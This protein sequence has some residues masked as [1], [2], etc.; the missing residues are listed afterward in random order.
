MNEIIETAGRYRLRLKADPYSADLNPRTNYDNLTHVITPTQS[1]HTDIDKD[2]G[3]LQYGWDHYRT[4]VDGE[5]MF[6]RW[7]RVFHGAVTVV[8]RP[9]EGAWGL[10]YLMPEALAEVT[11]PE[12]YIRAEAEEY[13]A[14][15]AGE[16]YEYVIERSVTWVRTDG[17]A[18]AMTTWEHVASCGGFIGHTYAEESAREAFAP[19]RS[20][21]V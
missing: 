16:V 9:H 15:A 19:Y 17:Q 1:W 4:R 7:A 2:G 6:I 13:R 21:Q 18:G 11:D 12:E 3:P 20:K 8:H 10:W 14:W 5:E